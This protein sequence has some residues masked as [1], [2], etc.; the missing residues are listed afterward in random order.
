MR[1]TDIYGQLSEKEFNL[2]FEGLVMGQKITAREALRHLSSSDLTG[3]DAIK[4]ARISKFRG[5][6]NSAVALTVKEAKEL[7]QDI[8]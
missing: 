8:V 3:N 1:I 6:L 7:Y 5:Y 4:K 2:Y